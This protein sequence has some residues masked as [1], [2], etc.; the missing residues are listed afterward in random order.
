MFYNKIKFKYIMQI[1][2]IINLFNNIDYY[3]INDCRVYSLKPYSFSYI[4]YMYISYFI[5][6]TNKLNKLIIVLNIKLEEDKK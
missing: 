3:I 2:D 4:K 5:T 6:K 1:K